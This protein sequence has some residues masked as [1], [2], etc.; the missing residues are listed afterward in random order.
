L[1]TLNKLLTM[2]AIIFFLAIGFFLSSCNSQKSNDKKANVGD[3]TI[4]QL[5]SEPMQYEAHSV[6]LEGTIVHVC[7]HSGDKMR[8]VQHDDDA[9]SIMV[10]LGEFSNSITLDLE[11]KDIVATGIVKTHIRNIDALANHDH[12]HDDAD[13]D[14]GHGC[15]ST[16]EAIARLKERGIEADIM[17]YVELTGFEIR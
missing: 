15:A 14:E 7:R 13:H 11:G 4:A 1:T 12:N 5:V 8:I 6:K 10:M 3:L 17:V 2:K 16:E 9:Y